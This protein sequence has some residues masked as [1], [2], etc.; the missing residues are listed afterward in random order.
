MEVLVEVARGA[1]NREVGEALFISAKTVSVHLSNA[2]G[3]LGAANR[4]A[5]VA[6][7][8]ELGLL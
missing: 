2:M 4:T 3:K 1:S 7:G 8:R 5:A 6:R